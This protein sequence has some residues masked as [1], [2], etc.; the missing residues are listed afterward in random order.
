MENIFF[1]DNTISPFFYG[2]F[3][4]MGTLAFLYSV[5]AHTSGIKSILL[6]GRCNYCAVLVHIC[7]FFVE[8]VPFTT[9]FQPALSGRS[10]F[11]EIVFTLSYRLPAILSP[12]RLIHIIN[13]IFQLQKLIFLEFVI[14]VVIIIAI[15]LFPSCKQID[16]YSPVFPSFSCQSDSYSLP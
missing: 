11:L 3:S 16:P 13:A 2:V 8:I 6:S 14:Y 4:F 1:Y 15:L 7:I 9:Y 5:C 12:A 10:I